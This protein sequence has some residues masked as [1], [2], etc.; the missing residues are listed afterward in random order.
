MAAPSTFRWMS[1][2]ATP[3]PSTLLPVGDAL[4]ADDALKRVRRGDFLLYE[5]DF[6]NAKQL[7]GAMG[8]RLARPVKTS[9]AL[10][11]FRAERKARALKHETLGRLVVALDGDYRLALSRAPDVALACRQVWGPPSSEPT[12]VALK[13]LLGMLGAAEWRKKGLAVPGL[14]RKLT[15]HYGVYVPTRTDYVELLRKLPNVKGARCFEV[16]TGTGVL[17]LLLLEAGAAS[18]V[19]TDIEPRA[20]ACAKENAE[21]FGVTDRFTVEERPLFPDGRAD[22]V[23]CN[24]P[25]LPEAPKNRVD[26]AV[27][28]EGGLVLEGFLSGL[29][30]HLAPGGRGVLLLS[31]LAELLGLRKAGWLES[32]FARHGLRVL[33]KT[34][35]KAKHGKAKDP[36]DRLHAVRSRETTSLYVLSVA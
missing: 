3:A 2:S 13:T 19:A 8:R 29:A 6:H 36:D 16:G 22:L 25:W 7:L 21:R 33:S 20:V 5:G 27:F 26:R 4:S 1:E 30:A 31:D 9:S 12:V 28:D 17:S 34:S 32:E 10:E 23:V 15:T 35:V 24:P 14:A 11:A 18:V